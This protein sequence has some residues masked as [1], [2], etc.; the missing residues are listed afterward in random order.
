MNFDKELIISNWFS[1]G[2][3][4]YLNINNN[5]LKIFLGDLF[6]SIMKYYLKIMTCYKRHF[7][8]TVYHFNGFFTYYTYHSLNV[9]I[10]NKKI[11]IRIRSRSINVQSV[12]SIHAKKKNNIS[13]IKCL[14]IKHK[15]ECLLYMYLYYVVIVFLVHNTNSDIQVFAFLLKWDHCVCCL[16]ITNH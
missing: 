15:L 12:W 7:W 3:W 8:L 10:R 9:I 14:D 2:I 11:K 4:N 6:V 13:D 5:L 1:T 16:P